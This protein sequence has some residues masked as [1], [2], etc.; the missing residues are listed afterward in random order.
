MTKNRVLVICFTTIVLIFV[1]LSCSINP[2]AYLN[3]EANSFEGLSTKEQGIYFYTNQEAIILKM[4]V[5][6]GKTD[7]YIYQWYS[8]ST[9]DKKNSRMIN[10][11]TSDTL[12]VGPVTEK[13]SI[14]YFYC[15]VAKKELGGGIKGKRASQVFSVANTGLPTV[16][17]NTSEAIADTKTWVE[18]CS[19]KVCDSNGTI[20]V[21]GIKVKGRGNTSWD[22]PK[23]SYTLKFDKK[24]DILG[25]G[26]DKKWVLI[27]NYSD[28]SLLRN[29]I[30]SYMG[31]NIFKSG[32]NPEFKIV[33]LI[34]N[35]EYLGTYL[36]G[37]QIKLGKERVNVE[38]ISD[39]YKKIQEGKN[40]QLSEGG[41]VFA[42]DKHD[43]TETTFTTSRGYTFVLKDPDPD[44][45]GD[46]TE[47]PSDVYDFMMSVIQHAEDVV[48]SDTYKDPSLGYASVIDVD[49]FIDFYF[50]NELAKNVD[51]AW[52]CSVYFYYNPDDGKIHMGPNW[53][54]DIAYGN[55]NY[56][57]CDYPFDFYIKTSGWF[58]RLFEDPAFS[59]KVKDRWNEKKA[60][61]Y[62]T[63]NTFIE[64]T[65][66]S[67]SLSADLNF[68]K[69]RILGMYVWP[70][71]AGFLTRKTY[72]SE[73]D[74]L[75]DWLN[76]RY[77]WL[78]IQF[79][80]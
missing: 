66:K 47:L 34:M 24:K 48:Y 41:F 49:S 73:I 77:E 44:N 6:E 17:I 14:A 30:A 69:W 9:R 54:F 53:D 35:G 4:E 25:M 19:I 2:I 7:D 40:K 20:Q 32:W 28:K 71:P 27:A 37:E 80:K 11:A 10:G 67:I 42:V 33:D 72:Q 29:Y 3:E 76:M 18:G 79:N 64:D 68:Q 52:S 50:V 46:F 59:Q 55:A 31:I 38:D 61:V 39:I 78:D 74:Y 63:I 15:E 43:D 57:N 51:G 22:R 75:V 62:D 8:C 5:P 23:K 65:A 45:F 16:Y 26:E 21:E 60:D 70:N 58:S 12:E 56:K 36:L 13:G 1:C